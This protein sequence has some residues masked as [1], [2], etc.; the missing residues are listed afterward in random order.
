MMIFFLKM[1]CLISL[2]L[3]LP[4]SAG[5]SAYERVLRVRDG[6]VIS[7]GEMI[8]EISKLNFIFIGEDHNNERHHLAQL[9]IVKALKGK[10]VAV[11]IGAEMFRAENQ[12]EI[13]LWLAG[14]SS[15]RR[16]IALY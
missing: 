7:F 1:A 10:G 3:A 14:K 8:E 9:D 16:F 5:P 2:L 4:A 11:A 13:D 6:K 12:K 15:M